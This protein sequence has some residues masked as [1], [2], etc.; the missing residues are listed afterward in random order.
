MGVMYCGPYFEQVGSH[1]GY[2]ARVPPD[3]E[4]TATWTLATDEF[5]AHGPACGCGWYGPTRHAPTE[6]GED[7]AVA[8]W[9]RCHLEPLIAAAARDGWPAWAERVAGRA[10]AV[11]SHIAAGR[12]DIAAEIMDRLQADVE[13]WARIASELAEDHATGAAR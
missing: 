9:R 5:V 8:E 12:P 3:G 11:A 1:E 13:A 7:A 2:A 10:I 4:L 6:A